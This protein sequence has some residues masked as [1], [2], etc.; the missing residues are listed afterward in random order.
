MFNN[1]IQT[2]MKKKALILAGLCAFCLCTW[3]A[4]AFNN[5]NVSITCM[6]DNVPTEYEQIHLQGTLML[7]TGPNAIIAGANDNSV[8]IRFNQSFGSVNIKIYNATGSLCYNGMVNTT[9]QQ[10]VII[11]IVGNN[12][13]FYTVMLDN[14]NGFAEGEFER[15]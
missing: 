15:N 3:D 4:Q 9:V 5:E 7:G 1:K 11:S 12:D 8:Y 2:I 10:T 14:A 6:E 13:G